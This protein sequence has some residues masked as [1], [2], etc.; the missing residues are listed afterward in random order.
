MFSLEALDANHGDC[1]FLHFGTWEDPKLMVIDGGPQFKHPVFNTVIKPR[2]AEMA[3]L[4]SRPMPLDVELLMVSHIDDDHI[5]GVLKLMDHANTAAGLVNV[6]AVWHNSF[7][8]FLNSSE[9]DA[10]ASFG[11]TSGAAASFDSWTL[12]VAASVKQGR[13]LRQKA[14]GLGI[15]ANAGTGAGFVS[16]GDQIQMG[17]LKITI[18]GPQ[19]S[20]LESLQAKW[21]TEN[22][23]AASLSAAERMR[24]LAAFTDGSIANLASI[25]ALVEQGEKTILLTGDARGDKIIE[26]LRE[27]H[28][29]ADN[30]I[31]VDVLKVPHHGSDRNV[32][33]DFFRKVRARHYVF[34]ADGENDNPD[35]ATLKM[36]TTARRNSRYTMWFTHHLQRIEDYF[37]E[38]R[39]THTRYY[40]VEFRA[41]G[42]TSLWV[43][44]EEELDF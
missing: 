7:D 41:T 33:T 3:D 27:A 20:E 11:G 25:V 34:S 35:T 30:K 43:D 4:L 29:L 21:D 23:A 39:S 19:R 42:A 5:G 38:D 17:S 32:S 36:L 18:L 14:T 37:E 31:T 28:L 24:A 2:L 16:A 9:L 44:L 40:D 10:L 26:G 15:I 12:G 6:K 22:P 8:D 1:L 13:S